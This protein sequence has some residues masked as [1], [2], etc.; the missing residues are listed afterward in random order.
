MTTGSSLVPSLSL[1][2]KRQS[3]LTPLYGSGAS[4]TIFWR[5]FLALRVP[6]PTKRV[7]VGLYSPPRN[8][9]YGPARWTSP[10]R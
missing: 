1:R 8:E 5:V 3:E 7:H 10:T 6:W 4:Q 9:G 2:V